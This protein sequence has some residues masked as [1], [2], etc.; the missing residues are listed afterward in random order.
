MNGYARCSRALSWAVGAGYRHTVSAHVGYAVIAQRWPQSVWRV[1]ERLL[2]K[3]FSRFEEDHCRVQA[4]K[5]FTAHA[6]EP[7]PME[8]HAEND[9]RSK[10]A[11]NN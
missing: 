5:Y 6:T 3:V 2:N 4:K 11:R 10:M 7:E 8:L 1:F 9:P